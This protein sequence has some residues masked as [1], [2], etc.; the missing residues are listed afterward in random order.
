MYLFLENWDHTVYTIYNLLFFPF[1]ST[2]WTY[3]HVNKY[4]TTS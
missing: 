1:N 3:I 2:E 4:E